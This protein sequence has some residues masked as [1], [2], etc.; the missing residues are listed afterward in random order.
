MGE[1]LAAG[2]SAGAAG[3][4]S[5]IDVL[6][7]QASSVEWHA[8]RLIGREYLRQ[9][10]DLKK[11]GPLAFDAFAQML[12]TRFFQFQGEFPDLFSAR[13]RVFDLT[14]FGGYWNTAV[15]ALEEEINNI[16]RG[17]PKLDGDVIDNLPYSELRPIDAKYPNYI[18]WM[19]SSA[20]EDVR[21]GLVRTKP[22][23]DSDPVRALLYMVLR[24]SYL[25]EHAFTAMRFHARFKNK[26][27]GEFL[28][29]EIYNLTFEF[30]TLPWDLVDQDAPGGW[31]LGAAAPL[32]GSVL[33]LIRSRNELRP[34][35][36]DWKV[37]FGDIDELFGALENLAG[38]PTARLER[39]FAEHMDLAGYRL[40]A[41]LT[42]YVYQ[43]LLAYRVWRAE[44]QADRI[45]PLYDVQRDLLLRPDLNHRPLA[46]YAAGIFLGAYGW[47]EGIQADAAPQVVDDLPPELAPRNQ[48]PVT[49]DADNHGLIHAPSI[50]HANSAAALR[51]AAITQP[52]TT[53]FNIDL[54]S[55]R[56]RDALWMMDGVRNGQMPAAL[57]GYRFERGLRERDPKLLQFLPNLRLKFPMPRQP[58]T[59]PGAKESV[60]ARDVVNG[61][62]IVQQRRE[63]SFE[64]TLD[65]LS[66]AA[67]RAVM[68][69]LAD[70]LVDTLDACGDLMLAESLH[71]AAQGNFDRAGGVVT[72]AGEFSHV[73]AEFD[74]AATPRSGTALSHR[75]VLATSAAEA[76]G[77]T[78]RARLEPG[79]NRWI[80]GLIG[81]PDQL[82]ATVTYVFSGEEGDQ[83]ES[84]IIALSDLGLEP[85]DLLFA[86]D[87]RVTR[88]LDR[89]LDRAARPQF[90]ALH[91]DTEIKLVEV[92]TFA[93]DAGTKPA[94]HVI[95]L[96]H[97]VR[98]LLTAA[99]P[100]T[101]RDFVSPKTLHGKTLDEIEGID[102][103]E[104]VGRVLTGP[105]SL[106]ESFETTLTAFAGI[107]A[108]GE[109]D[110]QALLLAA[111][112]FGIPEA[113]PLRPVRDQARRVADVM[114]ERLE[115]AQSK[116]I[117]PTPPA[118]D[119]LRICREVTETL[120]GS[121]FPLMPRVALPAEVAGAA[122]PAGAPTDDD[123][124]EWL[125]ISAAVRPDTARLQIVRVVAD[126]FDRPLDD[127]RIFQWPETQKNWIAQQAPAGTKFEG[128]LISVVV[129]P[130]IEFDTGAPVTG[131][132][133]DEW[134]EVIPTSKETT[135]IT[136]H[137]DAP[138]AEPP[139]TLLLAVSQRDPNNNLRWTWNE[140]VASIE[141]AL[142]L[143]KC[144]PW[145]RMSCAGPNSTLCCPQPFWRK[146][147]A[148]QPSRQ[149]CLQT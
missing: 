122:L 116:W 113:I 132:V 146:P 95:Q 139:Q 56:V 48:R 135:A 76:G 101:L 93:A 119:T 143:A 67:D 1:P 94:G 131:L 118:H 34:G 73:P 59:D 49:R 114:K 79:L 96:L 31:P 71:H 117:P 26:T 75:V 44:S 78:P 86:V 129:Q 12:L 140:L 15:K 19:L 133:I 32:P 63:G 126:Q 120:L 102:A 147:P 10:R 65:F 124:S 9:Y 89:R 24:H 40:D 87:D 36:T 85:I 43:R 37:L 99:R 38:L 69:G 27:W 3:N 13:P 47:V 57:L 17:T 55:S 136:F 33:S 104:L 127:L 41:W 123:V 108:L 74:V 60:P 51:S 137:Y 80:G 16:V 54:S 5:V 50:N 110:V 58:D 112:R 109:N 21:R 72:A 107:D 18:E 2:A 134:Q 23:G 6:A 149:A 97:Q 98:A 128:E 14:F 111:A 66:S 22:N 39:L 130:V 91:P 64:T 30:D 68:S 84:F 142:R 28:E 70:S 138:N 81:P 29:K 61:L 20:F 25:Y 145:V 42:G 4:A 77:D 45:N 141:Q 92:D 11:A 106:W 100:A 53:A 115:V 83:R 35:F 103:N 82:T 46:P 144:G 125:F 105:S 148:R 90:N 7:L 8:E 62:M 88:E 121:G 52:G